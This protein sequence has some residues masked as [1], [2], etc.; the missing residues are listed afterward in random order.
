MAT[1]FDLSWW[2]KSPAQ[3]S[4]FLDPYV[5]TLKSGNVFYSNSISY[6]FYTSTTVPQS[7]DYA[8]IPSGESA[9]STPFTAIEQANA[10]AVGRI[11]V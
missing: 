11:F 5:D 1:T 3:L 4:S 6:S 9:F 10:N 8:Y 7:S 2:A